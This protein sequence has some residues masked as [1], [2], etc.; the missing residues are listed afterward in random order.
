MNIAENRTVSVCDTFVTDLLLVSRLS[1]RD[2][3][4]TKHHMPQ[5]LPKYVGVCRASTYGSRFPTCTFDRIR[6]TAEKVVVHEPACSCFSRRI[7]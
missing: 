6:A 2:N 3:C 7:S 4:Q 1:F 5:Y